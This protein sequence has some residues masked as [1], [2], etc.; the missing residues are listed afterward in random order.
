RAD[1]GDMN[2]KWAWACDDPR[3]LESLGLQVI[4]STTVTRP[5]DRLRRQLPM[6]YRIGMPLAQALMRAT[7][8]TFQLTLFKTPPAT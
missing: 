2:A 1:Q 7:K 4:E 3:S 6:T 8:T 5:P